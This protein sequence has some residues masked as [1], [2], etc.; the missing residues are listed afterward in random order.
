MIRNK[1]KRAAIFCRIILGLVF[2]ILV[3]SGAVKIYTTGL[4][5]EEYR[6][7]GRDTPLITGAYLADLEDRLME[8]R[9]KESHGTAAETESQ[10]ALADTIVMVRG[11]LKNNNIEPERFRIT[12]KAPDES[13]EFI[14][15]GNPIPFL[16]FLMDASEN[17]MF[18]ITYIN[19]KPNAHRAGIDISMRVK[20]GR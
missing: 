20:N 5:I 19:I 8:L 6:R 18:S 3:I 1:P 4:A 11:L 17:K 10:G 14:I 16:H 13:A 15:H 2:V 7:A 9:R 12:G